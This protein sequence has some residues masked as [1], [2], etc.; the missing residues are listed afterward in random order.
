MMHMQATGGG[1]EHSSFWL[2]KFLLYDGFCMGIDLFSEFYLFYM[3]YISIRLCC[4][5]LFLS[6]II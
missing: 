4:S 6:E 3:S 5:L 2:C 1:G